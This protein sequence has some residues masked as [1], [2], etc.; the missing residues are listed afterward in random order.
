M[1]IDDLLKAKDGHPPKTAEDMML[2]ALEILDSE[3]IPVDQLEIFCTGYTMG[4]GVAMKSI[5][6]DRGETEPQPD[7]KRAAEHLL[8]F[9]TVAQSKNLY[10]Q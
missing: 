1:H 4:M 2:F 3:G 8:G 5:I 6:E 9:L 10:T 7:M